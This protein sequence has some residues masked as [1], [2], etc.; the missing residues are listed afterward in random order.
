MLATN[1]GPLVCYTLLSII[2]AYIQD[3]QQ[4]SLS[5]AWLQ[6]CTHPAPPETD[7]LVQRMDPR[8]PPTETDLYASSLSELLD[9]SVSV[10]CMVCIQSLPAVLQ[11]G[12]ST[13]SSEVSTIFT[14]LVVSN[15][16]K[17][18]LHVSST[19]SN[20]YSSFYSL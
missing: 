9:C 10:C 7:R 8:Y 3:H 15:G 6:V 1:N 5:T 13:F 17:Y 12:A 2:A 19:P 18:A 16:L 11:F 14:N 4:N 20:P